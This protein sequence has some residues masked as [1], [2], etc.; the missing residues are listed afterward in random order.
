MLRNPCADLSV[1]AN[2]SPH[3]FVIYWTRRLGIWTT[4]NNINWRTSCCNI[5]IYLP[6]STLTGHTDTVEHE[7]DT[8]DAPRR[9]SPQ[10]MKKEEECVA[11]MLT[12]GLIE[13]SNSPWSS[14]VV[15]VTKKMEVPDSVLTTT[16][17]ICD[18]Q[19]RLSPAQNG[20]YSGYVGRQTMV[21]HP[22]FGKRLLAGVTVT[23]SKEQ[24]GFATH[25][26][27]FQFKLMP[28]GL[29][30]A[31]ATFER[32][33]DRVLQG[34]RWS[35]CLVYLDVIISIRSTFGDTLDNLTL[36]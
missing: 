10:K 32:L 29:C 5:R 8:G 11:E 34:L 20:R 15:L 19:R 12:G 18:R 14:P 1:M 16:V 22:G 6:G 28:F 9:V 21:L 3:T 25:S 17:S 35:R 31:P 13:P 27:L 4:H 33:M 24:D 36:I 23:G 7:I 30:N 2:H 26:G